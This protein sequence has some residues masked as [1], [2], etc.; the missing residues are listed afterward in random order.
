M[1]CRNN[2][3]EMVKNSMCDNSGVDSGWVFNIQKFSLHDG[4]GIRDL[5]FMKGCALGCQWCANPE[6]QRLHPEIGYK[7]DRCIGFEACG[8]CLDMCPEKALSRGVSGRAE[9]D[10]S[11]CNHC[12]RCTTVC[13]DRALELIGR[14]MNIAE[15]L[16]IVA[17]DEGFHFRSAG[18]ITVGGGDPMMQANFV[19]ELLR[20]CRDRGIDTAVETAGYGGWDKLE[21]ICRYADRVFYDVKSMDADKHMAFTGVSNVQILD[22]L[23]RLS[24]YCPELPIV[25]RTPVIPGFNDTSKDISAIVKFLST[26]RT[27]K[28]YELLPYHKFG[29]PKYRQFGKTYLCPDITPPTQESMERLRAITHE[30]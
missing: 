3:R 28:D 24:I 15:I 11:R 21:M 19:G 5:I 25:A 29:T 23:S 1:E 9:I 18:G 13:P 27:L 2:N 17:A 22:N 12:G 7:I 4:P 10:R 16:D 20:A 30:K 26:I 8:L 6:S 14:E